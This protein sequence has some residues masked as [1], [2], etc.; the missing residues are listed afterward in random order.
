[1]IEKITYCKV[2]L[3]FNQQYLGRKFLKN[4]ILFHYFVS[5]QNLQDSEY[6][7][8]LLIVKLLKKIIYFYFLVGV[9]KYCILK[10]NC[11]EISCFHNLKHIFLRNTH[12]EFYRNSASFNF[13][14]TKILC[15]S[16]QR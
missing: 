11:T 16:Y 14:Q 9:L 12:Y 4:V 8:H 2:K 3:F 7:K 1:M 5:A 15:K 13:A 10:S 6:S